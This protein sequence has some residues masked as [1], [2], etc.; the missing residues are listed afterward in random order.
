MKYRIRRTSD[1]QGKKPPVDGATDMGPKTTYKD[2][3]EEKWWT[4]DIPNLVTFA[5]CFGKIIVYAGN[6]EETRHDQDDN[7]DQALPTVEIYDDYRE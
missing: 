7:V 2:E 4:I 6:S 1:Y 5:D 3:I